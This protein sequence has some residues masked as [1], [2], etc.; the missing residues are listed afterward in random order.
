MIQIKDQNARILAGMKSH[1]TLVQIFG[2]VNK[3]I[4][5]TGDSTATPEKCLPALYPKTKSLNRVYD[6]EINMQ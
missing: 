2:E 4:K 1:W 3:S 5:P 6:I